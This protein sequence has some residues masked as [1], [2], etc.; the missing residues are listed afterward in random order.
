M[1]EQ[2]LVFLNAVMFFTRIPVPSQAG[3]S[4]ERL[5]RASMYFPLVGWIVGGLAAGVYLAAGL[6]FPLEVAV[7]LSMV[8]S[9]LLTGAFHEDG[10]ADACDGF[11]GGWEK[12]RILDIMKDSRLG[13]FGA[14]GLVMAL[15]LKWL[16]LCRLPAP[17]IAPALFAA[18][19]FSR[20]A[21]TALIRFG[22]YARKDLESKSKPLAVQISALAFVVACV[23]GLA[24]FLLYPDPRIWWALIPVVV[25]VMWAKSY[26]EKWIGGY[27]GDCLG[28]IQQVS[29]LL[30]YLTLLG[31][32]WNFS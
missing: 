2:V 8:S 22:R 32:S 21:S 19:S 6:I 15:A 16:C 14:V 23:F 27:T 12:D 7:A 31:L 30:T 28:A 29:E 17:L 3:W 10:L 1:R 5:N 13:T 9:L 25:V 11:G 4:P 20:L 24:P 26:F 18:H